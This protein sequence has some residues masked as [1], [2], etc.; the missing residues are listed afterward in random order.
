MSELQARETRRDVLK[1]CEGACVKGGPGLNGS[2]CNGLNPSRGGAFQ[3]SEV[4]RI[5]ISGESLFSLLSVTCL[6]LTCLFHVIALGCLT[7][8]A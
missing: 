7:G 8:K 2:T 3:G 4:R 1:G 5:Y 6:I